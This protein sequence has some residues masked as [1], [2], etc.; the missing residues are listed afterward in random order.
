MA[1]QHGICTDCKHSFPLTP[2][3]RAEDAECPKC[4]GAVKLARPAGTER[5]SV[6]RAGAAGSAKAGAAAPRSAASGHPRGKVHGHAGE[7]KKKGPLPLVLGGAGLAVV[8][9]GAWF[10]VSRGPEAEPAS[11]AAPSA[12]IDLSQ[13]PDQAPL[14]GT[15]DE[16]WAALN[17]LMTKYRTPPFSPASVPYGDRMMIQGKRAIPA[18]LNGFK[19][20]DLTTRDGADIGWKIQTL[21]LQGLCSDTNFG[22]RRETRPADV[23]FNQQVIQTWFQAWEIAGED[24]ELWAEIARHKAIPPGLAKKGGEGAAPAREE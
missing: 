5:R 17:E 10:F 11:A 7:P 12:G 13:L 9:L 16:Q 8:A 18:I 3:T 23:Q 24:D 22:W 4:G 1:S 21:L 15:S 2:G 20:L 14:E 6:P 19:R